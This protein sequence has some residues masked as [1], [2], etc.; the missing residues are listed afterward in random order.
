MVT[1]HPNSVPRASHAMEPKP[2]GTYQTVAERSDNIEATFPTA[3]SAVKEVNKIRGR[4]IGWSKHPEEETFEHGP[5][6]FQ[7]Q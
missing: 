4:I 2:S 6:G 5:K 7:R 3:G 1:F